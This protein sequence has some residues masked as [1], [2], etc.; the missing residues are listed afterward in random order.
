MLSQ[1]P[2]YREVNVLLE[3]V[4]SRGKKLE[5]LLASQHTL[6]LLSEAQTLCRSFNPNISLGLHN[7]RQVKES[8]SGRLPFSGADGTPSAYIRTVC[9]G[10][11]YTKRNQHRSHI[12]IIQPT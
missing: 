6:L 7:T 11:W 5:R 1:T 3:H 10:T 2:C 4:I 9:T 12:I 8:R